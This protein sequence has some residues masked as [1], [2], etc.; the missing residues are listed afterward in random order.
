MILINMWYI[1]VLYCIILCFFNKEPNN[2]L[3]TIIETTHVAVFEKPSSKYLGLGLLVKKIQNPGKTLELYLLNP[4][5]FMLNRAAF[6][7]Q[8]CRSTTQLCLHISIIM[9]L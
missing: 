8:P 7:G 2:N 4:G 1:K 9:W 6:G 5:H 3:K